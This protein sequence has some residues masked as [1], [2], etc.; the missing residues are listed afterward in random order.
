MTTRSRRFFQTHQHML[1]YEK[2]LGADVA[3]PI[4]FLEAGGAG[5]G[6]ATDAIAAGTL[7]EFVPMHI[8]NPP[9]ITFITFFKSLKDSFSPEFDQTKVFGRSDP[10]YIWKNSPRSIS[11]Q[12][13]IPSS[14]KDMALRNLVNLQWLLAS[15][16]PSYKGTDDANSVSATPLFRVKYSN[17][18]LSAKNYSGLLCTLGKV[19]VDHDAK[20]G[21][22]A[23]NL[24]EVAG[25]SAGVTQIL[26]GADLSKFKQ[27]L[28]GPR[29]VMRPNRLLIPNV[30]TLGCTL[31]VV[32]EHSL[33]WE[34]ETGKW[35]ARTGGPAGSPIGFP[36]GIG[37]DKQKETSPPPPPPFIAPTSTPPAVDPPREDEPARACIDEVCTDADA[38]AREDAS[39]PGSTAREVNDAAASWALPVGN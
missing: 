16:Y 15:L 10:Y 5:H 32:H 12:L 4:E 27:I 8:K 22:M 17:M 29:D 14:G 34:H 1:P 3:K 37:L 6:A 9:R 23:F 13:N 35:R 25:E 36:Y 39:I 38:D 18:I 28:G 20:N 33:G 7:I 26:P 2:N 11:L 19:T 21:F 30:Y 24:D 31:N